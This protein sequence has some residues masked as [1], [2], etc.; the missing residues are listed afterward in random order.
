MLYQPNNYG[1]NKTRIVSN[2]H[3]LSHQSCQKCQCHTG[4]TVRKASGI[5]M[6]Y[7]IAP[8]VV[9]VAASCGDGNVL[10]EL[11]APEQTDALYIE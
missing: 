3:K 10:K 11:D 8:V 7:T 2:T 4:Y 5:N 6:H 9:I 1:D